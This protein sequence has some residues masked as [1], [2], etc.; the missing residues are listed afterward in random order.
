MDPASR[1][2]A[3]PGAVVMAM[4]GLDGSAKHFCT[5][6]RLWKTLLEEVLDKAGID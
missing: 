1:W 2:G 5:S 6:G 3:V 4:L